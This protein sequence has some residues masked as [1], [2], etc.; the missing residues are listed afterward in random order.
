[1]VKEMAKNYRKFNTKVPIAEKILE[2]ILDCGSSRNP[3]AI[4]ITYTK[5]VELY[6]Q[7][8]VIRT[9]D[10]KDY[11]K[12][13]N[14]LLFNQYILDA[15]Q[16]IIF[17]HDDKGVVDANKS[18]YEFFQIK[19]IH[20]FKKRYGNLIDL[21]MEYENY[22]SYHIVNDNKSW[23]NNIEDKKSTNYNVLLMNYN[24]FE[25]ET[26]LIDVNDIPNSDKFVVTLTN[27][28]DLTR[29]SKEFEIKANYD[30]LT[31]IYNRNKFN[32]F[33]KKEYSLFKRYKN[34]TCLAILDIDF[35]K[36]VNDN[37]GH[38]TGDDLL[39]KF[40][41]KTPV[42]NEIVI[43]D[44]DEKTLGK[45]SNIIGNW[46]YPRSILAEINEF[47]KAS[48][49]IFYDVLFS[50]RSKYI[51]TESRVRGIRNTLNKIEQLPNEHLRR[52]FKKFQKLFKNDDDIF[53]ESLKKNKNIFLGSQGNYYPS[54]ELK[55]DLI[56]K[57]VVK[58]QN[59][60]N[61][62][63]PVFDGITVAIDKFIPPLS[64]IGHINFFSDKDGISRKDSAR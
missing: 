40:K 24:T 61:K 36:Q 59:N 17:I 50:E 33:L 57:K 43:I 28:T 23:V 14:E 64:G 63:F 8:S 16:N 52:F 62:K 41:R 2:G 19:S 11:R 49:Y 46:P 25:P 37:Y 60:T 7:P 15:Q 45:L 54:E 51:F 13:K 39:I 44:I 42:S 6:E 21:F 29:K 47:L 55:T 31:G 12:Y 53:L 38:L 35:F 56:K 10:N 32:E 4:P 30:S 26:F 34:D 3:L 9:F 18:F 58:V 27:I 22:F 1:M 20:E 5:T 48:K